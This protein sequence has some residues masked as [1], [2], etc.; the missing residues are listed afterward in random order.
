MSLITSALI[1]LLFLISGLSLIL[2]LPLAG[3]IAILAFI[4]F[5]R[6]IKYGI[7]KKESWRELESLERIVQDMGYALQLYRTP[8]KA[9]LHALITH[10]SPYS[11]RLRRILQEHV[12][13]GTSLKDVLKLIESEA[14]AEASVYLRALRDILST[15]GRGLSA[16]LQEL[17][18][19]IRIHLQ[20]LRKYE[21]WTR[22]QRFRVKILSIVNSLSL[23]IMA[24]AF[25]L[26]SSISYTFQGMTSEISAG[27]L[28]QLLLSPQPSSEVLPIAYLLFSFITSY[29][30]SCITLEEKPFRYSLLALLSY[31]LTY[32]VLSIVLG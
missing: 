26:L 20:I 19:V 29:Y 2:V 1:A 4:M 13:S 25:S 27:I 10:D 15:E 31:S 16:S 22:R 30:M 6:G 18:N 5:E 21:S 14:D 23:A 28:S 9:I 8:E 11:F 12:L 3:S 32:L 7:S 24:K 17:A